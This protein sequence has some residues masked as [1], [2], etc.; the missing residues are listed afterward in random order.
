MRPVKL[1]SCA[2]VNPDRKLG[3][4][5]LPRHSFMM[6][7]GKYLDH[8]WSERDWKSQLGCLE[9]IWLS[10][11]TIRHAC[12]RRDENSVELTLTRSPVFSLAPPSR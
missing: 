6:A 8:S 11:V 12:G 1:G 2:A 9:Y 4:D 5:K 7:D 3:R 10:D